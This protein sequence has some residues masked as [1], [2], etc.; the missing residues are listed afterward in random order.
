MH[1]LNYF[2]LFIFSSLIKE[3]DR[4]LCIVGCGISAAL[5]VSDK[6]CSCL[7]RKGECY[8]MVYPGGEITQE[9]DNAVCYKREAHVARTSI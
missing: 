8:I 4:P 9:V 1:F 6:P 3:A 5:C 2:I 7:E